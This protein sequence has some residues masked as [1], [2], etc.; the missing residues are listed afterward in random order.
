MMRS[1]SAVAFTVLNDL[2]PNTSCQSASS[3]TAFMKASVTS[4]ETLNMRR[5]CGSRLASMKASMSG[6][7]QRR[8]AIMAPRREPAL[9]MVRH[10]ASQTSMKDK[11][12]GRVGADAHHRRALRPQGREIVPDAAALLH[13]EGRLA[14]VLED[15]RH[16]VGDRAH[17]EAVEEGDAA[18][19]C[20]RPR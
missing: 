4:T 9:M 6:W 12:T 16:V 13:R 3:S 17:D 5:R 20:R 15:A 1:H 18:A 11:R 7:S 2:P 8:V 14:Q 19:R 10:I